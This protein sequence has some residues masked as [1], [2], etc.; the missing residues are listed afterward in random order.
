MQIQNWVWSSQWPENILKGQVGPEE[1][2]SFSLAI[3]RE[4]KK[5]DE[6]KKKWVCN[7]LGNEGQ[8]VFSFL[9]DNVF[10]ICYHNLTVPQK[11]ECKDSDGLLF[12]PIC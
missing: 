1:I 10:L 4:K 9:F 7:E 11:I 5:K 3:K 6:R 12:C 8:N 2:G